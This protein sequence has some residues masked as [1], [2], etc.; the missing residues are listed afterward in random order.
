MTGR[1]FILLSTISA[2]GLTKIEPFSSTPS[3]INSSIDEAALEIVSNSH[4]S[5]RHVYNT[6]GDQPT[7]WNQSN[8]TQ[9]LSLRHRGDQ[10]ALTW[11]EGGNGVEPKLRISLWQSKTSKSDDFQATIQ[12]ETPTATESAEISI[13][14]SEILPETIGTMVVIK[15]PSADEQLI[16]QLVYK[17]NAEGPINLELSGNPTTSSTP[18]K[19]TRMHYSTQG[20]ILLT[21]N[22][23]N[24]VY[25]DHISDPESNQGTPSTNIFAGANGYSAFTG[26]SV[27]KIYQPIFSSAYALGQVKARVVIPAFGSSDSDPNQKSVQF[28]AFDEGSMAAM[29]LP[30][31]SIGSANDSPADFPFDCIARA[32]ANSLFCAHT[33]PSDTLGS[34]NINI[35]KLGSGDPAW[36][37]A[38]SALLPN[39]SVDPIE[40]IRLYERGDEILIIYRTSTKIFLSSAKFNGTAVESINVLENT[41]SGIAEFPAKSSNLG[42]HI[43]GIGEEFY[44]AWSEGDSSTGSAQTLRLARGLWKSSL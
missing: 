12:V 17:N 34:Y 10:Y 31:L 22:I 32:S 37:T 18:I 26:F 3:S 8:S 35:S 19:G 16:S 21:R 7:K 13:G 24:L 27:E 6:A 30:L 44:L 40:T 23:G 4:F 5:L 28:T 29:L 43:A 14:D 20:R 42:I 2:C 36:S 9:G 33:S 1:L 39:P 25:L 41:S 38:L 11:S 15:N